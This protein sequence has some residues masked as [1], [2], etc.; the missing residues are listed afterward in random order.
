[1]QTHCVVVQVNQKAFIR[2]LSSR[3]KRAIA[4]VAIV[5]LLVDGSAMTTGGLS[6]DY[7]VS[8]IESARIETLLSLCQTLSF[9][10]CTVK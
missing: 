1:M 2:K 6:F 8:C 10:F 3:R 5:C 9:I 7:K 4:F